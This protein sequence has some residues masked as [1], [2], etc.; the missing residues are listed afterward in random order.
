MY[1]EGCMVGKAHPCHPPE[2]SP[3]PQPLIHTPNRLTRGRL[4]HAARSEKSK[5]ARPGSRSSSKTRCR[6]GQ[7]SKPVENALESLCTGPCAL[8]LEIEILAQNH[9]PRPPTDAQLLESL[10]SYGGGGVVKG[11]GDCK[12]RCTRKGVWLEKRFPSRGR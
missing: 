4:M 2:I 6:L 1:E 5:R 11:A 9:L 3:S 12:Y 8:Q 7:I 10:R